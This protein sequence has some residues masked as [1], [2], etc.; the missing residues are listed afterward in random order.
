VNETI[1]LLKQF[2]PRSQWQLNM[3]DSETVQAKCQKKIE[4]LADTIRTMPATRG[5]DG[6]G[7]ESIAYLHYF[8]GSMHWWITE[9]D[10]GD[11]VIFPAEQHQAFGLAS[12]YGSIDDAEIGYISLIE[13]CVTPRIELD[14]RWTPVTLAQIKAK[15]A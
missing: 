2:I 9:K 7:D 4:S 6:K 3:M 1:A 10:V 15:R 14:F 5:Q 11:G 12:L 13:I 8:Y